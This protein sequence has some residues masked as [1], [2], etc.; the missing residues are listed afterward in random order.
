MPRKPKPPDPDTEVFELYGGQVRLEFNNKA[1]QRYKVFDSGQVLKPVSVT[2][3]INTLQKNGLTEWGVRCCA[4]YVES[5]LKELLR[6]DSFS[7]DA[8]FKIVK[9]SRN[10]HDVVRQ[11]AAD[12]G[13][14]AHDWLEMYWKSILGQCPAPAM[15]AEGPVQN[16]IIA[17]QKWMA[18]HA[19]KPLYIERPFYS[20]KH[21]FT[22]KEDLAAMVDGRLSIVDYKSGARLYPE[23][24]WQLAAYAGMYEEEFGAPVLDRWAIHLG[25]YDGEFEPKKFGPDTFAR[26]FQSFLSVLDVYENLKIIRRVEK[27]EPDAWLETS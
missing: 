13:T 9:E 7:I 6:G 12:I 18:E 14:L 11:E 21:K 23:V 17:A 22:G 2:T 5:G 24:R 4:D 25:K 1:K 26:D 27:E 20:R 15:P 8:I 3:A 10:A 19:F 16:C